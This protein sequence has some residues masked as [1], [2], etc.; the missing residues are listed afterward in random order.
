MD[1][2]HEQNSLDHLHDLE[3]EARVPEKRV[4]ELFTTLR[5]TWSVPL[6]L[7]DSAF[8]C[9]LSENKIEKVSYILRPTHYGNLSV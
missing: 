2:K 3:M 5:N 4:S 8:T 6:T 1:L 7:K 9:G